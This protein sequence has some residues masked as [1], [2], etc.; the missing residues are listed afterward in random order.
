M[1]IRKLPL[2][3]CVGCGQSRPKRELIR[4]VK[5]KDGEFLVDTTGKMNGRGAYICPDLE[6]LA[7]ARKAKRLERT[8]ECEIP[9]R[10]YEGLEKELSNI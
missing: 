3:M 9:A 1:A 7:K 2:R 10:I 8:F 5:S 6:C 4:V